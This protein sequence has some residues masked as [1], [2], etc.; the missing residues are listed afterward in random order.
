LLPARSN[1]P[2][3]P[4]RTKPSAHPGPATARPRRGLAPHRSSYGPVTQTSQSGPGA[5][6]DHTAG[7]NQTGPSEPNQPGQMRNSGKAVPDSIAPRPARV[8]TPPSTRTSPLGLHRSH[9]RVRRLG[10]A[11]LGPHPWGKVQPASHQTQGRGPKSTYHEPRIRKPR[12]T[13][14]EPPASSQPSSLPNM[15]RHPGTQVKPKF[16]QLGP[17]RESLHEPQIEHSTILQ[18]VG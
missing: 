1:D 8:A 9:C 3:P 6:H 5:K 10:H 2:G 11:T 12:P 7:P 14:R 4:R 16:T 18:T 13:Q 15:G 17:R